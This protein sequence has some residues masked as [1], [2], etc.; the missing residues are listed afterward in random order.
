MDSCRWQEKHSGHTCWAE[1]A[2]AAVPRLDCQGEGPGEE[3][4]AAWAGKGELHPKHT[5]NIGQVQNVPFP[6]FDFCCL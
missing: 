3:Q 5:H 4:G 6:S 1:C 2:P